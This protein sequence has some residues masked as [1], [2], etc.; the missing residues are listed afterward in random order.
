[1]KKNEKGE[2]V[3]NRWPKHRH[4]C[5]K[6]SFCFSKLETV[7]WRV[8]QVFFKMGRQYPHAI[9]PV[10]A[11]LCAD[12]TSARLISLPTSSRGLWESAPS[13][14]ESTPTP[15]PVSRGTDLRTDELC[16]AR[17]HFADGSVG[18]LPH[19]GYNCDGRF[20]A[21]ES[22]GWRS[23]L[24]TPICEFNTHTHTYSSPPSVLAVREAAT[25]AL[26]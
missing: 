12:E 20:R 16:E 5:W 24:C 10:S 13:M 2:A 25:H 14:S 15:R 6:M 18:A 1:M 23:I 17:W 8:H 7:C 9:L 19:A 4:L 22:A 26:G 21:A 11:A 3:F